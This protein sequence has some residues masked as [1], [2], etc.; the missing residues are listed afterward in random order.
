MEKT[1]QNEKILI[2]IKDSR[3]L[4]SQDIWEAEGV[5]WHGSQPPSLLNFGIEVIRQFP[6]F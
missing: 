4:E 6:L 3:I 1:Y 5:R 2:L